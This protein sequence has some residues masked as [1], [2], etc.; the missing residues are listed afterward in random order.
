MNAFGVYCTLNLYAKAKKLTYLYTAA[1]IHAERQ[2]MTQDQCCQQVD[3][4]PIIK[5]PKKDVT[6]KEPILQ[7]FKA[8]LMH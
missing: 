5:S 7:T 3:M 6:L 4:V 1:V 2:E 8:G